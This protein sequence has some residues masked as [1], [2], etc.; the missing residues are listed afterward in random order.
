LEF[1]NRK[2]EDLIVEMKSQAN[3]LNRKISYLESRWETDKGQPYKVTAKTILMALETRD[4]TQLIETVEKHVFNLRDSAKDRKI[5]RQSQ[6]SV[7]DVNAFVGVIFLPEA[8]THCSKETQFD[9][10]LSNFSQT[11]QTEA[12]SFTEAG[13]Q[14]E[15][16]K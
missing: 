6:T 14:T 16:E 4:S 5:S 2:L 3:I 12:S 1:K 7:S 8:S 11:T 10:T 15:V 13:I 9:S